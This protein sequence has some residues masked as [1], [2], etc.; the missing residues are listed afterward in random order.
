[1]IYVSIKICKTKHFLREI[2]EFYTFQIIHRYIFIRTLCFDNRLIKVF[3]RK[4]TKK[5][6]F[7][8]ILT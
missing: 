6:L 3:V 1:M 2:E 4:T 7:F 8:L 5:N